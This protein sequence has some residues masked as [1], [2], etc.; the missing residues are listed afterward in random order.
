MFEIIKTRFEKAIND[1]DENAIAQKEIA[2]KLFS[3]IP[4]KERIFGSIFEFGCGTGNF[5]SLLMTL[6]CNNYTLNDITSK[7]ETILRSKLN[8][9][10]FNYIN[11]CAYEYLKQCKKDKKSFDMIASTSAIQWIT[12]LQDFLALCGESLNKDGLLVLSS[13][14]PD[15]LKEI[16]SLCNRGLEYQ[17]LE[18]IISK[19]NINKT[20]QFQTIFVHKDSIIVEFDSPLEV[21]K[22]LKLTGVTGTTDKIWT[23]GDLQRFIKGYEK[24]K[25]GNKYPLTYTPSYIICKKLN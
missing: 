2:E 7:Y 19:I 20:T 22:H 23:K 14:Q 11:S 5:S 8:K 6:K 16:S 12:N 17:D 10:D 9:K 24:Y 4:L 18:T 25:K 21:L 13:F 3:F 1:Y 15:N